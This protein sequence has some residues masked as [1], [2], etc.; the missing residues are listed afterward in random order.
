LLPV[1]LVSAL[2]ALFGGPFLLARKSEKPAGILWLFFNILVAGM[3]VVET[4]RN[5]LLFLVAW[6][7]MFLGGVFLIAHDDEKPEVRKAGWIYLAG[8]HF[9]MALLL[10]MFLELAQAGSTLEFS[11]AA[12]AASALP[13]PVVNLCFLLAVIGFGAKAGVVPFHV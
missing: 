1:F 11:E 13:R 5:I 6:E 2:T 8:T 3:V 12:R 7:V 4:A 9:G 10:P